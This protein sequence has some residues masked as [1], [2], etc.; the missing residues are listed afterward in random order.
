M[1][2]RRD[3]VKSIKSTLTDAGVTA[4]PALVSALARLYRDSAA[5]QG[6]QADDLPRIIRAYENELGPATPFIRESLE[7]ALASHPAEWIERAIGEAVRANVRRWSY[8]EAVL[9]NWH[10]NGY[11]SAKPTRAGGAGNTSLTS[12]AMDRVFERVN[13]GNAG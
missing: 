7:T 3:L 13:N 8:A 1:T 5:Q 9:K 4:E 11:G 10:V 6:G 2:D 12:D